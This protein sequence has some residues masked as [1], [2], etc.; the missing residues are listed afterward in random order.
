M[1]EKNAGLSQETYQL[2]MSALREAS[3]EEL[4]DLLRKRKII[5]AQEKRNAAYEEVEAAMKKADEATAE[6]DALLAEN[7]DIAKWIDRIRYLSSPKS[8]VNIDYT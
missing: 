3:A 6:L 5:K 2:V 1:D 4:H 7:P 8:Y